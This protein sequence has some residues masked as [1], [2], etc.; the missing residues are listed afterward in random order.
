LWTRGA[1]RILTLAAALTLAEWLRG[2]VLTGF[3]W[4]AFGY[5]LTGSLAL[6]Q[7]AALIGLWGLT[8][9]AIAVFASPAAL[10]DDRADTRRPWLAPA[11]ALAVLAGLAVYGAVRLATTPTT[12]VPGVQLRIMQPN[13]PQD[14]RFNYSAKAE[15]IRRYLALS[16]RAKSPP[17]DG[18]AG[19]THLI[20]P[21]SA[22]PFF[23]TREPDALAAIGELL[24]PGTVLITGAARFA[25]AE[26]GPGRIRAY[27]S[28]YVIDDEGVALPVYDKVHLV[29]FGEFLP[30]RSL[31]ERL[32]LEQL[33]RVPGG[34]LAG[35][36]RRTITTPG[37][38]AFVPLVCYEV[39]FPHA[40][41]PPG[42][43]P[44]WLLNVTNDAWFGATAGPYQ[45]LLQARL[46]AI[47]EGLPL[48]RA[49]NSGISAVV[50]PLGRVVAALPLGHEGVVD[51]GL[52]QRIADPLYS[53]SGDLA[54]GGIIGIVLI[55]SFLLRRRDRGGGAGLR[56]R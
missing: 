39:I 45:H 42:E 52:P 44:G 56:A 26:S 53:R 27:N 46:R 31:L 7:A 38:P 48:V 30:L 17:A 11:A 36:R 9:I 15:V 8:F 2:H 55:S 37:A 34:F 19:V 35:E 12:F 50:D 40:V 41:V 28:V 16:S 25:E 5:S 54:V 6:A 22:F 21:E 32:G 14:Q 43:R 51:S 49:A 47:E 23:L 3:P 20:W 24:P 29:P 1:A 4:N 33:V 10:A 18:I 13:I